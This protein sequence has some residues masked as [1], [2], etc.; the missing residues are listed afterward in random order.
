MF[1]SAKYVTTIKTESTFLDKHT[2]EKIIPSDTIAL[3][4]ITVPFLSQY[5]YGPLSSGWPYSSVMT[6]V[7]KL[8]ALGLGCTLLS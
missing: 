6:E 2:Y 8:Y 1:P 5:K 4:N 3:P 7:A